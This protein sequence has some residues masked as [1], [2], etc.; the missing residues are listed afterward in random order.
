LDKK[1]ILLQLD[2]DSTGISDKMTI[3]TG[4]ASKKG[5]RILGFKHF[6]KTFNIDSQLDRQR[7]LCIESSRALISRQESVKCKGELRL[8]R[9]LNPI[10]DISSDFESTRRVQTEHSGRKFVFYY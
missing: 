8:G 7:T 9:L 3:N 1:G 2:D 10:Q 6:S 5:N 4:N